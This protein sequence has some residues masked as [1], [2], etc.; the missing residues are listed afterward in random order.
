MP[1][2]SHHG[3]AEL[4]PDASPGQ[5]GRPARRLLRPRV[6]AGRRAPRRPPGDVPLRRCGL[7][8]GAAMAAPAPGR[9]LDDKRWQRQL[10]PRRRRLLSR[11]AVDHGP[12]DVLVVEP[13]VPYPGDP[14][15]HQD[16]VVS[17]GPPGRPLLHQRAPRRSPRP[18][19]QPRRDRRREQRPPGPRPRG[20]PRPGRRRWSVASAHVR[21]APVHGRARRTSRPPTWSSCGRSPG[22]ARAGPGCA[23]TS[24]APASRPSTATRTRGWH[25]HEPVPRTLVV[26]TLSR[27]AASSWTCP[28]TRRVTE[29]TT[30]P[31][32]RTRLANTRPKEAA[33]QPLQHGV[34]LFGCVEM[35]DAGAGPPAPTDRRYTQKQMWHAAPR[36]LDMGVKAEEARLRRLLA[37]RAPLPARGLRGDPQRRA[38]R[39]GPRRADQPHPD[40]RDVPHHPPVAPAAL[41]RGLRHDAQ[42][43]RRPRRARRRSGHGAPRGAAAR[44]PDRLLRQPRQGRGRPR[45]PGDDGRGD[46][47]DP[48]R[49]RERVVQLPRPV[50]RLPAARHPRPW[51]ARSSTSRS[52]PGRCYP[53]EIWQPITSPPT[54]EHVPARGF[55]GVFWLLHHE[56]VRAALGALRRDLRAHARHDAGAGREAAAGPQHP[57]RGHPRAGLG[58]GSDR[59]TTSSGSSSGPYGWSKGYMGADGKPAPAGLIPTLEESVEQR[60]WVIGSPEEVAEG[61]ASFRDALGLTP[62]HRVPPVPRRDVRRGRAADGPLHARGGAAAVA[63]IAALA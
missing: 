39:C 50:L 55:G 37:H 63:A 4:G 36:M 49:L 13:L 12:P 62:P 29:P 11:G 24:P 48:R 47:R 16:E 30:H 34:F 32:R 45:Q 61:I 25:R 2:G 18:R 44:H 52:C 27:V 40:R 22:A 7:A 21:G 23:S 31:R 51:A 43:L 15:D 10:S 46:G 26:A 57:G 54:L 33:L 3:G 28:S 6:R 14:I 8:A 42:P 56:F 19:R 41:R 9:A 17:R 20:H 35:D 59:A 58:A 38:V 1:W 5:V 53:Y 60:V